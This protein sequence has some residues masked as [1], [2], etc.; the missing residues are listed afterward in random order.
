MPYSNIPTEA[1]LKAIKDACH[2]SF[3][4]DDPNRPIAQPELKGHIST[5][6]LIIGGGFTGLWTALLAKEENPG[7]DVI[8]LEAGEIA[9]GASGRNG[10][11]VD[12]SITHGL[13]NGLRRWPREFATLLKLGAENLDAIEDTIERLGIECD[14][15]RVGDVLM[16]SAPYQVAELRAEVETI[17]Q[18]G[19]EFE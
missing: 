4:L 19:I 14:Y 15:R 6:L 12:E 10:G 5:D 9:S 1:A 7:R 13:Q 16:A 11:F 8:L 17:Q 2:V 18:F 3:W